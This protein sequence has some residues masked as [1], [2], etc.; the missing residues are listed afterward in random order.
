[1][2][3]ILKCL[4]LLLAF[5]LPE[6]GI[7]APP[8]YV[9]AGFGLNGSQDL[10]MFEDFREAIDRDPNSAIAFSADAE[11][12]GGPKFL[13]GYRLHK[14][15]AL[16]VSWVDLGSRDTEFTVSQGAPN[17]TYV[18]GVL[19]SD[20]NGFC[21]CAAGLLPV[22]DRVDLFARLGAFLWDGDYMIDLDDNSL[23]PDLSGDK[24][25]FNLTLGLGL[26]VGF[27]RHW[28]MRWELEFYE[29]IDY[30]VDLTTLEGDA[31][32]FGMTLGI[33]YEI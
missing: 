33:I 31:Y 8:V 3:A 29:G 25:G 2:K 18:G 11:V 23:G 9:F 27:T 12:G 28:G 32:V 19:L 22:G 4:P 10:S 17:I 15:L 21:F 26:D 24:S 16:E 14:N 7:A 6:S 13:V 5:V 1:M 20:V 30:K